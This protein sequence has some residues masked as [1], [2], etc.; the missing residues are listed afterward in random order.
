MEYNGYLLSGNDPVAEIRRGQV[1]PLDS[2]RMPLYLAAGGSFEAW[3]ESR[4]IDRHRPNSRIL[5]KVLRLSDSS[6]AAAVLRA[7]AATITDNYWVRLDGEEPLSYDEIRFTEDTFAEIALSGSFCSYSRTYEEAQLASGSPELT[8][9]GSYEKCW[10]IQDGGWWLCKSGTPLERFSE[11]FIARLGERLGFSMA[12][13][14]P[15]GA[16]VKTPDFTG[17]VY[18]FEPAAAIVGDEEGYVFN[19]DRLT[20][21]HPALGSQ[22]LDILYMDAL[23]FNMDRHTQNYGLLRDPSTGGIVSMAPNFDNNIALISR[24]YGQDARQTNGFLI[25][26]FEELLAEHG[27]A[28]QA[29]VLDEGIIKQIAKDTLPDEEIDR[30]YVVDMV[31]ERGQRLEDKIQQSRRQEASGPDMKFP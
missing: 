28:Y 30:E 1:V 31:L 7:H 27:L 6:D 19:Y 15:D 22:Y 10:R 12:K 20:V 4:A 26:L 21:L 25:N 16:C 5:K 24:G 2:T 8:N 11:L 9:I 29:P 17:G 23:C 18:N 3:L 13:Y 14:V